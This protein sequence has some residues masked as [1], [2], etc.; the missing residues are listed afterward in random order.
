MCSKYEG[1]YVD[2]DFGDG[3]WIC[4]INRN[5][6]ERYRFGMCKVFVDKAAVEEYL[7]F[8]ALI[9]WT[10]QQYEIVEIVETK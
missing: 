9:N 10:P 1:N 4:G 3:Y 8:V 5:I 6:Q 7:P 2:S